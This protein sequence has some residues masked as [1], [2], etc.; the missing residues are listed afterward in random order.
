MA[1]R[2]AAAPTTV[3]A[4]TEPTRPVTSIGSRIALSGYVQIDAVA[5][6]AASQNQLAPNGDPLNQ[7]RFLVRRARLRA[8]AFRGDWMASI[9]L[10]GNTVQTATARLQSAAVRW[11]LPIASPASSH[12]A[13]LLQL[14]AGMFRA[15]FGAEISA[16]EREK[17]LLEQPATSRAFF[18]GNYDAGIMATGGWRQV[19]WALALTNGA[20][21]ADLQFKGRDPV[22]S[23]D[24]V[25]RI[26]GAVETEPQLRFE[27]GVSFVQGR[28]LSPGTPAS[29]DSLQWVDANNDGIVQTTELQVISGGA[30][31]PSTL[32][33]HRAVALDAT[34]HWCICAIGKGSAFA[35][36]VVA[37]NLDRGIEY[38]DPVAASRTLREVG[39]HVGVAQQIGST[40][41]VAARYDRYQPDRDRSG[42]LGASRV[43][44][45]PTYQTMSFLL[46]ATFGDTRLSAQYDHEN[47]PLG[48]GADGAVTSRAA[49]RIALRLQVNF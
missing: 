31:T 33:S 38:A 10:D 2:S 15:P 14:T 23:F 43:P 47:N 49:D 48:R 28:S 26:G 29:K 20:P 30:G 22:K 17:I 1:R 9:E 12:G 18:P 6:N 44:L 24:V 21:V 16:S 3:A 40:V 42:T 46:A 39:G 25:G 8:E 13:P 7:T 5:W 11:T 36:I 19:R 32:F 37:Q 45:D 34:V 41:T 4:P 27:A 35:E